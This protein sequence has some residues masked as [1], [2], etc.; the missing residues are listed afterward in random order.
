MVIGRTTDVKTT[1]ILSIAHY[2]KQVETTN[3]ILYQAFQRIVGVRMEIV[4][5]RFD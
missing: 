1:Y 4:S 3:T 5:Q 2:F